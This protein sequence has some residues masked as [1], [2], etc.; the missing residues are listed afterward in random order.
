VRRS[1]SFEVEAPEIRS[2]RASPS[3]VS[4]SSRPS[5]AIAWRR[6]A[7]SVVFIAI[8][9]LIRRRSAPWEDWKSRRAA[10]SSTA[11]SSSPNQ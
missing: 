5:W 3:G 8:S 4:G 9:A 6:A 10:S 11:E 2:S 7:R 1:S